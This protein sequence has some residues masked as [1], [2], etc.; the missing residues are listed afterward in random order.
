ML[1]TT[2]VG[3]GF[4]GA[5]IYDGQ[6]YVLDRLGTE[7]D[8]LRCLALESGKE[9]WR[10]PFDARGAL[11][12]NGSRNVPTVTK[13]YV[14]A[15]SPFGAIHCIDR[16][17]H[18]KVWTHHLVMDFK[19]A[20]FDSADAGSDR[21]AALARAQ[22]PMWGL[23][24]APLIY[25]DLVIMAPQTQKVGVVAYE[26]ATGKIRWASGYIGRNWYS[27]VSPFLTTLCGVDQII[28]LAQPSDPEKSPD[29]APPAIISS[30]DPGTGQILWTNQTPGPYKIPISEPTSLGSNRLFVTGGYGLGCV[31]IHVEH[32]ADKW[33][34]SVDFHSRAA[35]SHIQTPIF[36]RGRIYL[37]SFKEHRGAKSGLVCLRPDLEPVWQ[38]GPDIQFDSG[39]YL[40]ANGMIYVLHG[41]TGELSL[42]ELND[43]G[44]RLLAKAKVLE[45]KD[46]KAWA[47]MAL[48]HGKLVLRDQHQMKCLA[49][50]AEAMK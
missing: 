16:V 23:T 21:Q 47:P 4:A 12:F 17:R 43:E 27:H 32:S 15:V 45:A 37:T 34:S 24:Q 30:I 33:T 38:T 11:P 46:G 9:L 18:Q 22:L 19:D 5:A 10:M 13:D 20:E 48:S 40:I 28:M 50:G 25:R 2:D 8:V 29:D 35:A 6:V 14:F 36:Y 49:V 44:P 7:E 42:F 26:Q 1:W 31:V 39:P 41:K 3:Q